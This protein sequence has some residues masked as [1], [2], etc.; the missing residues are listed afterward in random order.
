MRKALGIE[1]EKR[2]LLDSLHR[3]GKNLFSISEAAKIMG[4]SPEKARITLAYF[5]R[6]GWLA[7]V[8]P[9][10]YI[11]VPLGSINPQEYKENPWIVANRVFSP[12]YIAGCSAAGHWGLTDQ[13]FNTVFV[14]TGKV[15]RKK[16]VRIQGVDY[17]LKLKRDLGHTKISWIENVKTQISDPT[18]TIIDVLEDPRFGGGM[19]LVSEVVFNYFTSEHYNENSLLQYLDESKNRTVLKR[20]GY[21]LEIMGITAPEIIRACLKKIS[22]G[23]SVLDPS[24]KNKGIYNSHWRLRVNVDIKR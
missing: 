7:R 6:R 18:M 5:S 14:C 15:F 16:S 11:S 3:F 12:C 17:L 1:E 9:G 8:K 21:I 19:R 13:I 20:L 22:T 23:Y 2:K 24:I 10:L 4:I